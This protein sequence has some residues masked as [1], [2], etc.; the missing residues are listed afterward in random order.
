MDAV[1]PPT[2]FED[3]NDV[4]AEL[5]AGARGAL[6]ASFCGAYLQGSFAVGDAD[7]HSDVDFLVVVEDELSAVQQ[8]AL[9]RLHARLH[10]LE[11]GW[12]QHLEGSY[13]PRRLLRRV[14]PSRTPFFYLDN[15]ASELVW[16]PHCNTAVARWSLREHGVVLAGP[17]P[18][19][20]VEP[21]AA[22]ELRAE[23]RARLAETAAWVGELH[24]RHH[25]GER[26]AFSR[27]TQPYVVLSLCRMLR[28]LAAGDV[29]SK[30]RAG[31]W[32]LRTLDRRW[33][34]LIQAAL[35]DRPDPWRRVH[36][37]AA[38]AAIE[39]TVALAAYALGQPK[40]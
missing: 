8:V 33:S 17:P 9:R 11:S 22:E 14:D 7:E 15:G 1:K 28:T 34:P 19:E 39:Q 40:P 25:A 16:D 10:A 37:P 23:A 31:E 20:L 5:V 6:G 29:V 2:P 32:A 13:A 30:R 3:L 36:E 24:H 4:L 26:M 21:V 18:P 27:W 35:D 38:A 12:A